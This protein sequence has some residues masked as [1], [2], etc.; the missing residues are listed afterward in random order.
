[1]NAGIK[2]NEWG[3]GEL[4][5]GRRRMNQEDDVWEDAL[6]EQDD[7]S[8]TRKR[9]QSEVQRRRTSGSALRF[10]QFKRGE[11]E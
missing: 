2:Q 1:M 10:Q 8:G 5:K 7:S 4:A 9:V 11:K 6:Q 3:R